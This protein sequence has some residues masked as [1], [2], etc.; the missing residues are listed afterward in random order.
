[1]GYSVQIGARSGNTKKK[2][3]AE[4][5]AYSSVVTPT[6]TQT[7]V[8]SGTAT[9]NY[10]IDTSTYSASGNTALYGT[11]VKTGNQQNSAAGNGIKYSSNVSSGTVSSGTVSTVQG[12]DNSVTPASTPS[13]APTTPSSTVKEE[14][15]PT[16]ETP[17]GGGEFVAPTEAKPMTY[18][19]YIAFLDK[20]KEE[21][22]NDAET[23]RQRAVVDAQSA[24]QQNKATYGA[25]AEKLASMGLTGG[26]YSEYMDSQAYVQ[27]RAEI[28]N[29]NAKAQETKKTIESNY[30]ASV[31]EAS[32]KF[33]AKE[34]EN[35]EKHNANF[36][37][38]LKLAQTSDLSE[39]ELKKYGEM[40][41]LTPE[42]IEMGRVATQGYRADKHLQDYIGVLEL[43]A[44]T[45]LSDDM[46]ESLKKQFNLTDEEMANIRAENTNFT[47]TTQSKNEYEI[48]ASLGDDVGAIMAAI[49]SGDISEEFGN[50]K[51]AQIQQSNFENFRNS[52]GNNPSVNEMQ[53]AYENGEISKEQY[54]SLQSEYNESVVTNKSAFQNDNYEML[55]KRQAEKLLSEAKKVKANGWMVASTY[56]ELEKTYKK[57]YSV[58]TVDNLRLEMGSVDTE[59]ELDTYGDDITVTCGDKEY[60]VD[61]LGEVVDEHILEISENVNDEMLFLYDDEVYVRRNKKLYK[62]GPRDGE[63]YNDGSDRYY[64]MLE[65]FN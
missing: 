49:A 62:I 57:Y 11:S 19:E 25:N 22:L 7:P 42:E 21:A 13:S 10:K 28:T 3:Y 52:I 64:K 16:V 56:N 23:E 47:G 63:G 5:G 27:S 65:L 44:T 41:G 2:M 34:Q 32:D 24:Y 18:S 54:L 36:N 45:Q 40:Y 15:T 37:E 1:M 20:R 33:A 8:V 46:L 60:E 29:A 51:I 12:I 14:G 50:K 4:G 17:A 38:F 39:D 61:S 59:G 43:A 30:E 35:T 26:G 6:Q 9:P 53:T 48:A 58:K 55:S 31:L